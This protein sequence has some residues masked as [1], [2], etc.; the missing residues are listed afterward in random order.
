MGRTCVWPAHFAFLDV[1]ETMVVRLKCGRRS[2]CVHMVFGQHLCVTDPKQ[3]LE[4]SGPSSLVWQVTI[5]TVRPR[6]VSVSMWMLD[7]TCYV[8]MSLDS[9]RNVSQS[10][11]GR[12]FWPRVRSAPVTGVGDEACLWH[13][14]RRLSPGNHACD[15]ATVFGALGSGVGTLK[16]ARTCRLPVTSSGQFLFLMQTS[17]GAAC[18]PDVH[19]TWFRRFI[20]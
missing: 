18:G 8:C 6:M 20:W 14:G 11:A 5:T 16:H 2:S 15:Q 10:S 19:D 9:A 17:V 3:A 12:C 4:A 13:Q 7:V 1:Y